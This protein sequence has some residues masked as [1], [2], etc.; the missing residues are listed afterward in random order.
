MKKIILLAFIGLITVSITACAKRNNEHV[1]SDLTT[2]TETLR[3]LS[4]YLINITSDIIVEGENERSISYGYIDNHS[5]VI[6]LSDERKF[7]NTLTDTDKVFLKENKK[8]F[9][10]I[11]GEVWTRTEVSN[12]V[13]EL[14]EFDSYL[15]T[16]LETINTTVSEDDVEY[17]GTISNEKLLR[18]FEVYRLDNYTRETTQN[19]EVTANF[20]KDAQRFTSFAIDCTSFLSEQASVDSWVVTFQY[21][22][23]N[24]DFAFELD[25]CVDDD[26]VKYFDDLSYLQVEHMKSYDLLKGSIDYGSDVDMIEVEFEESG[27]YTLNLRNIDFSAKINVEIYDQNR[28]LFKSFELSDERD[29]SKYW[30]FAEA[31]YYIVLSSDCEESN[32]EYNLLFLSN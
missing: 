16:S 1:S 13:S 5:N 21:D 3:S 15:L 17:K 26:Y 9:N 7:D 29:Y 4:G 6:V 2:H 22:F 18:L 28:K 10:V 12:K 32:I 31:K 20:D 14:L 24:T 11:F 23:D 30:N 27:L 8:A 19:F 25:D